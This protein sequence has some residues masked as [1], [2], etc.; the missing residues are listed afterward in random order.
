[1]TLRD[2]TGAEIIANQRL[3]AR[4]TMRAGEICSSP[5]AAGEAS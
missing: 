4:W 5:A 1:V 2:S 3:A